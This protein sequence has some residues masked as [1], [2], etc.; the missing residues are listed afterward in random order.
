M[1]PRRYFPGGPASGG[2]CDYPA[3]TDVREGVSYSSGS[4]VGTLDVPEIVTIDSDSLN[5]LVVQMMINKLKL[6]SNITGFVGSGSAARIYG[7]HIAT[8]QNAQFPAISI[9]ILSGE[10]SGSEAGIVDMI[11]QVDYWFNGSGKDA[12]VW[13]DIMACHHAAVA[14]LHRNGGWDNS[15]GL[16]IFGVTQISEGPQMVEAENNMLHYNAR[17]KVKGFAE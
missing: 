15:V 6:V 8:I 1:F 12:Y 10:K 11:V 17:F 16:R 9:S 13:D 2:S 3:V 7:S 5:V 4:L 14:Q